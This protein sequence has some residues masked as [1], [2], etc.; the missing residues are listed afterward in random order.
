MIIWNV[1][2][3]PKLKKNPIVVEG[4]PGIGNVGKVASEYLAEK[5]K[6]TKFAELY[7]DH[8]PYHVFVNDDDTVDLP[9]NEFY[10]YRDK[11]GKRDII[12][13]TGD[14]Q[15]MTPNGH[16][17]I[18]TAMLDFIERYKV[19]EIFTLGGFGVSALPKD[20]KVLGATTEVSVKKKYSGKK[21]GIGFESGERVGIIIG[22]SGLLLGLGKLRGLKGM[23]LMGETLSRP[24]FTDTRAASAVLIALSKVLGLR[25]DMKDIETRS[26]EMEKAIEKA[27]HMEKHMMEKMKK[28]E[29]RYIG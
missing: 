11:K 17:E 18:V 28:E 29:F 9:R 5:L 1:I 26:A 10:H 27:H 22:A 13:I 23:C 14:I 8:Y 24:M 19:R 16:Y 15:S 2:S 3:K 12:I 20:P 21:Y 7:S 6:A 25:I 4:L